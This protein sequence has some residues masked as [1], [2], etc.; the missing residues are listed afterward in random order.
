MRYREI[1]KDK[2]MSDKSVERFIDALDDYLE[3]NEEFKFEVAMIANEDHL[4]EYSAKYKIKKLSPKVLMNSE[5]AI[6]NVKDM[7]EYLTMRGITPELSHKAVSSA[8]DELRILAREK[9]I[10]LPE[11]KANMWDTYY[12]IAKAFSVHW[13]TVQGNMEKA[14]KVACEHLLG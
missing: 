10:S 6:V 11:L 12:T 2:K 4:C 9:G 13:Y 5:G 7:C 3:D 14:A 1:L 8:Y